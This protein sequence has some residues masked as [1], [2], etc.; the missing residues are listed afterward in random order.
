MK[1]FLIKDWFEEEEIV[2]SKSPPA[3][4]KYSRY[5]EVELTQEEIKRVENA[6]AEFS[7]VQ[8][9]LEDKF[10]NTGVVVPING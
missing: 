4:P 9:M 10:T 3:F 6:F 8:T 7:A 1:V 5:R 2:L